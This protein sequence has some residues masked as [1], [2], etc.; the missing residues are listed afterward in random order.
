[1]DIRVPYTAYLVALVAEA[2]FAA[3][4]L[5]DL[6]E[7]VRAPLAQ[8]A[9]RSASRFSARLDASPLTDETADAVDDGRWEAPAELR[10]IERVAGWAGALRLDGMETD[11]VAAVEYAN[12]LAAWDREADVAEEFFDQPLSV[13]AH[14]HGVVCQ[15]LV[16]PDAIGRYRSTVQAVHDG[17]EGRVIFNTADPDQIPALMSGL[18]RWLR[19]TDGEGSAAFPAP[20]AAAVVHEVLLQ[21]QP[22][23]AANGRMA[24]TA[25]RLV[26]RARGMDPFGLAVPEGQWVGDPGGYYNEVA[27]T[28]RR[29]GDLG[30]WAERS[31]EALVA[32][33][34][35][36]VA[37]T[38]LQVPR[39]PHP[40]ALQA[41]AALTSGQAIT[42]AEYAGRHGV[43]RETAWRDLRTLSVYGEMI[44]ESKG[45]GR[46]FRRP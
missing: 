26:L 30:P 1:M 46:R 27:A 20:V 6:A 31:T 24:R 41:V 17:A 34:D 38:G 3:G 10:T 4:R 40:R 43:S 9:R 25:S 28:I 16:A 19:G 14:L 2:S 35:E 12:L 8:Q 32:A 5:R 22:F 7:D 36:A 33:L 39:Q 15:G 29:R 21:W 11:D 13:L 45:L 42:V 44:R 23:E 37:A 18:E